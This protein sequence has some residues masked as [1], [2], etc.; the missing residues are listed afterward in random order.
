MELKN[1]S[2]GKKNQFGILFPDD[3][4]WTGG[5]NYFLSLITSLKHLKLNQT[6]FTII[7]SNKNKQLF[8][9]NNIQKKNVIFTNFFKNKSLLNFCKENY[10]IYN[11]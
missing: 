11:R 5:K 10:L 6:N 7:S 2:N 3:D 8:S 1:I 4:V 9:Q